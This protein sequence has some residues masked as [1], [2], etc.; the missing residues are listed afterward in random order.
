MNT[1]VESVVF[2]LPVSPFQD[3]GAFKRTLDYWFG[4][5]MDEAKLARLDKNGHKYTMRSI[6]CYRA[7]EWV[8][9]RTE[10]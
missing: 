9:K 8:K 1:V 6:R 2:K 5:V 4:K 7:T 10:C 3:A